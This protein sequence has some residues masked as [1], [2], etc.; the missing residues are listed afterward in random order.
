[1]T[2]IAYG[3]APSDAIEQPPIAVTEET[4]SEPVKKRRGRPP[5]DP[6]APKRTY[7]RRKTGKQSLE[8][9]IGGMLWMANLVFGV[10]PEPWNGDAFTPEEIE[11]LAKA[12]NNYAQ[13]HATAYRYLSLLTAGGGSSTIQLAIVIGQ[14]TLRRLDNHGVTV[15]QLLGMSTRNEEVVENGT[16]SGAYDRESIAAV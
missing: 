13:D 5:R 14:I 2:D 4:S 16:E 10:M 8:D 11:A 3:P 1:M 15:T 9:G 12:L 6:N 7:T